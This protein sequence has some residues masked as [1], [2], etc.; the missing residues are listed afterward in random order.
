MTT[1]T[2]IADGTYCLYPEGGCWLAARFR[3]GRMVGLTEQ[4]VQD[5]HDAAGDDWA[6][7]GDEQGDTEDVA[8]DVAAAVVAEASPGSL[9]ENVVVRK[10][11]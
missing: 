4:A 5:T 10:L 8:D 3:G 1:K 9:P 2:Q 6:G 7:A 11:A